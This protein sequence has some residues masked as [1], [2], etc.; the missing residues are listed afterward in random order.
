MVDHEPPPPRPWTPWV[1]LLPAAA[2]LAATILKETPLFWRSEGGY[3][4]S[5]RALI[6]D[7]YY[8]LAAAVLVSSGWTLV[9][10]LR[11][12]GRPGRP[13]LLGWILLAFVLGLALALLL[14]NNLVNLIE[15]RPL[16][17]HSPL[18]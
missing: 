9:H 14:G 7:F 16:H 11:R 18:R 10:Q 6:L 1:L 15:G 12:A 5:L 4:P 13:A 3:P 8:P 17:H 2:W